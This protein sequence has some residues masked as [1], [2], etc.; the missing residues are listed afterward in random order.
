MGVERRIADLERRAGLDECPCRK[1]EQLEI[2]YEEGG[3]ELGG[4]PTPRP[5]ELCGR[6]LP[7]TRIV[8]VYADSSLAARC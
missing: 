2:V 3:Q 8:V 4:Q 1:A 7:V 5:C 6:P